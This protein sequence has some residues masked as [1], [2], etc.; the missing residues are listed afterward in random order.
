M[1]PFFAKKTGRSSLQKNTIY[2]TRFL[3]QRRYQRTRDNEKLFGF[4]IDA[5]FSKIQ[6]IRVEPWL[7]IP[8]A[9][10]SIEDF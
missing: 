7:V 10:M 6:M 8:I 5:E 4:Q 2:A 9:M 3:G 1:P